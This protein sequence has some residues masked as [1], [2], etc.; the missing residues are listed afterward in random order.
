M[1]HVPHERPPTFGLIAGTHLT[2]MCTNTSL[3]SANP[4]PSAIQSGSRRWP[5]LLVVIALLVFFVNMGFAWYVTLNSIQ[6]MRQQ[7]IG[8]LD[9]QKLEPSQIRMLEIKF[10]EEVVKGRQLVLIVGMSTGFG[11]MAIGFALFV[12]GITSGYGI[13]GETG[14]SVNLALTSSSPGLLCFLLST[15]IMIVAMTRPMSANLEDG[16]DLDSQVPRKTQKSEETSMW[17]NKIGIPPRTTN[18]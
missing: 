10:Y 6:T 13:T 9:Q 14:S 12:L 16:R 7:G 15:A 2:S 1:P 18:H 5:G 3:E 17:D 11:M 8:A 4:A